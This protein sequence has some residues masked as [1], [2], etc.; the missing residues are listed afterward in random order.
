MHSD[1]YQNY[2]IARDYNISLVK[3]QFHSVSNISRSEVRQVK[4]KVTKE[5]F[6]LVTVY[7]VILNNLQKVIKN[8][9]Q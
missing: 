5:N 1:E 6:H 4:R 7:N 8:I 2:L 9:V 3:K